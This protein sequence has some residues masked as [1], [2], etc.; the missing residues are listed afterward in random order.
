VG[1][2]RAGWVIVVA[3]LALPGSALT[4]WLLGLGPPVQGRGTYALTVAILGVVI[5]ALIVGRAPLSKGRLSAELDRLPLSYFT[6]TGQHESGHSWCRPSC[7]VVV[8]TYKGPDLSAP[9]IAGSV[10]NAMAARRLVTDPRR[11]QR[12]E[13][14]AYAISGERVRVRIESR[15]RP[16]RTNDKGEVIAAGSTVVTV[17]V[18]TFRP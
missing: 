18:A 7:P 3:V 8:R 13:T 10:V 9:Q 1:G 12:D 2:Y 17:R 15:R 11:L 6:R 14:G 16:P 5:A 4:W